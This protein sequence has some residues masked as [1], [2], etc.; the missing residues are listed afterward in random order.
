[1]FELQVAT[2]EVPLHCVLLPQVA[3]IAPP[4]PHAEL[5]V[6]AW[7]TFPWQQPPGQLVELQVA[8][9]DVPLHTF[10]LPQVV[11]VAPPLPHAALVLPG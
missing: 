7:Q 8:T 4:V 11:H 3:H 9:H 6:P 2:H 5:E 10:P 1:L